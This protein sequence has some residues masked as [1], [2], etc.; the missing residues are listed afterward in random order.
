[1]N[2]AVLI[3]LVVSVAAG[4]FALAQRADTD[5]TAAVSEA[6]LQSLEKLIETSVAARQIEESG[7][8]Q[9][10]SKR[11]EA[12]DLYRQTVE[13]IKAG[14]HKAGH[15]LLNK[16]IRTMFEA[17]RLAGNKKAALEKREREYANR[18]E[19]LNA[20][21]DTHDR[22]SQEKGAQAGNSE[23]RILVT[24]KI[25]E[26][27]TLRK[28]GNTADAREVLDEA[29]AAASVGIEQ[30]RGGETLVRELH[31]ETK[32]DE[33]NYEV[34]RNDTHRMLVDLLVKEKMKDKPGALKMVDMFMGKAADTR[35]LAEQQAAGGDF[36]SAVETMELAT[37][38][39]LR[40]IRSAGIYIPE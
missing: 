38:E 22:I 1:M 29:Y 11:E 27:E 23:L 39:I 20:L 3:L 36:D 14:D 37:K 13:A 26:S 4:G 21:L 34:G 10:Q 33:Y 40:A 31:F 7:N 32:E 12:K 30:L 17:T 9:A 19:S 24:A 2:K 18:L 25:A 15:D 16:A 5:P 35:N 6:R 28:A 8:P